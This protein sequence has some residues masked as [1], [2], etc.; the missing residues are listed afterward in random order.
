[1]EAQKPMLRSN[2]TGYSGHIDAWGKESVMAYEVEATQKYEV[3][4][5]LG[6]TPYTNLISFLSKI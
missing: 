6:N 5:R 3:T 1:M 4:P 2:N